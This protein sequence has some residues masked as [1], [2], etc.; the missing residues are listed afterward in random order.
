MTL[1]IYS[2]QT[3]KPDRRWVI[4]QASFAIGYCNFAYSALAAAGLKVAPTCGGR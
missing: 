1:G 2:R 3:R 4:C